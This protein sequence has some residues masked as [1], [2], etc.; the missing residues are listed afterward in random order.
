MSISQDIDHVVGA[1][2]DR[3]NTSV[4]VNARTLVFTIC[5]RSSGMCI[6]FRGLRISAPGVLTNEL[7]HTPQLCSRDSAGWAFRFFVPT[8]SVQAGPR[9]GEPVA[10]LIVTNSINPLGIGQRPR[11]RYASMGLFNRRKRRRSSLVRSR[12]RHR[13]S[14]GPRIDV[15]SNYRGVVTHRSHATC[16]H[17]CNHE[18]K[19]SVDWSN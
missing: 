10:P 4:P 12:K 14:L 3:V 13:G 2:V 8:S 19:R 15:R 11:L 17:E 5:L 1:A 18:N 7:S 9:V 16:N 6:P